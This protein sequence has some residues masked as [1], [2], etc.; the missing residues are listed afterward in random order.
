MLAACILT[1]HAPCWAL[2]LD[3]ISVQSYLGQP[4]KASI[5]LF[6]S[7]GEEFEESCFQARPAV[8]DGLASVPGITISLQ[9]RQDGA[10]LLLNSRRPVNEP[11][12][13]VTVVMDCPQRLT[14]Q[15]L[16]LLDPPAVA[17]VPVVQDSVSS[18]PAGAIANPPAPAD[19]RSK[20]KQATRSRKA[21]YPA[22]IHRH[23]AA[24]HR[25]SGSGPRLVL[26][27][28]G[29]GSGPLNFGLRMDTSLPEP[30]KYP[31]ATPT[32][33]DLSDENAS[34]N[35]KLTYLQEQLIGLQRR[36]AELEKAAV[37]PPLHQSRTKPAIADARSWY[38]WLIALGLL[39]TGALLALRWR[40]RHQAVHPYTDEELS[41]ATLMAEPKPAPSWH[42]EPLPAKSE[43]PVV[44]PPEPETLTTP[45]PQTKAV[46]PPR[47]T[48]WAQD[49]GVE[50]D[51]SVVDEVE[52]F[53]AH[54]HA[55]LAINLLQEH[56]R[57]APDESP[58]PWMLLLDLLRRNKMAR[59]YDEAGKACKLYFNIRIPELSEEE[60]P[61]G[62]AGLELYPH[63]LAELTRLWKTPECQAYL[64]DLIFDRRGG[65]RVGFDPPT[66]REIMLL[67]T[68]QDTESS[69]KAA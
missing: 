17:D 41:A 43:E 19:H 66:F 63:V 7:P 9:K 10:R 16:V 67:R 42:M 21:V 8:D 49:E 6:A 60:P 35:H 22:S 57:M 29:S 25:A 55:D 45:A 37:K 26:S 65:T 36:N 44:K 34:L 62:A 15:Y 59:E 3:D 14:R 48:E 61:P 28:H 33:T 23:G 12:V 2:G 47:T 32:A 64:D 4:F 50:V 51:D 52:V 18:M 54:G 69:R 1:S 53:M 38:L 40:S 39:A 56:V 31:S 24:H 5:N 46:P 68:I 11:A 27:G 58:I 30:G 20:A 13:A